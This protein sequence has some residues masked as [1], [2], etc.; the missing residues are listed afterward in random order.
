MQGA[1]LNVGRSCHLCC[2]P[3]LDCL[4]RTSHDLE[5]ATN[6][7]RPFAFVTMDQYDPWTDVLVVHAESM[8][9]LFSGD[10]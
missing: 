4:I 3:F 9:A 7:Y 5:K 10:L 2:L 6:R 1:N 8:V